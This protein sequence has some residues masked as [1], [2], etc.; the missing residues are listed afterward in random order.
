VRRAGR[1]VPVPV[2]VLPGGAEAD[3]ELVLAASA[4]RAA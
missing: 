4:D 3:R 1:V 2:V